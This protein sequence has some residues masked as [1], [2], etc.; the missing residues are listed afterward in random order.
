M[1]VIVIAIT[2]L[3]EGLLLTQRKLGEWQTQP[4]RGICGRKNAL[5]HR[6]EIQMYIRDGCVHTDANNARVG[7]S[8]H[9]IT[10]S[11][12]YFSSCCSCCLGVNTHQGD[13]QEPISQS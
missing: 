2:H 5:V 3:A 4:N 7:K 12:A 6:R 10:K 11:V 13:E 1:I 9:L 8:E